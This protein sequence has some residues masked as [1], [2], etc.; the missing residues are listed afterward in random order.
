MTIK[1]ILV[2][3]DFVLD[4]HIY[5]GRRSHFGDNTSAG[6]IL[7][8]QIGGA[9]LVHELLE[10][11]LMVEKE[12]DRKWQSVCAVDDPVK[13]G[14]ACHINPAEQ[15]FAFWRPSPKKVAADK[16]RYWRVSESM[17]FG[18]A[19]NQPQ[20]KK[21]TPAKITKN[22]EIVVISEGGMGFR[23]CKNNWRE[24]A[25]SK[26]KWIVLKTTSPVANGGLWEL[27]TA[28]YSE[29]L[30]VIV[31]AWELRKSPA[32]M[33]AGLSW[34]ETIDGLL[35]EIRQ[36]GTLAGLTRC[37]HLIV[38]FESESALWLDMPGDI[39]NA[40]ACLVYESGTIEGDHN[41]VTEGSAYGFIS[42]LAAAVTW[43]LTQDADNPDF[44]TAL[45]GGLSAMRNLR[46]EGHGLAGKKPDGFPA[47]RLAEVIKQITF[48]YSRA[49]LRPVDPK[50]NLSTSSSPG[51][52]FLRQ[53]Q[54]GDGPVYDLARLVL[55]R[56]PIALENLPHLKIGNLLT[57]D[58]SEVESL[59]TLVQ[60]IRRY[61]KEDSGK[62]PLSIGVFGPPGAGK[63]FA[64][65]ELASLAEKCGWME[66]NLS[67][68]STPNELNGAFHQI[69]D[70]VLQGKLPVAFFDEFD[71][72]SYK[73][74][75]YLLAPMQDG[76]F[77]DGQLTHTLGKCI[78][79]FAGGTSPTYETFG[80]PE[81]KGNEAEN[82]AQRDFRLAKG[83]DFKSRLDAY[84]DVLGPNQR[85]IPVVK[86]SKGN[87]TI[88]KISGR[89][90]MID[91]S[92]IVFPVRRALMIRAQL[93]CGPDEKL[94]MDEGLVHALLHVSNYRHGNRSLEK[95]LQPFASV[96]PDSLH[97]SLLM[98]NA[99]LAMYTDGKA[100]I[101]CCA[102]PPAPFS[103]EAPLTKKQI[104]KIAPAISETYRALGHKKG[105]KLD[106]ETDRDFGQLSEFYQ[107]SNRAAAARMLN[108]LA[109]IGLTLVE[110]CASQDEEEEA[111]QYLEYFLLVLSEA[112]HEGW[113]EWHFTK[114][115]HYAP[116]KKKNKKKKLHNCLLPFLQLSAEDKHKDRE[117][118]RHYPDFARTA[119]MKIVFK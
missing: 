53:T 21:M 86:K 89:D 23:E 56:G 16:K 95:I 93:K 30:I 101:E 73:W 58:R 32:R 115:W 76:K 117:T 6:V 24:D 63:S 40:R 65:K 38:A 42:C 100:F 17:G 64:V 104:E 91:H 45:E 77:Q 44:A 22:P 94:K 68:F 111:K 102:N 50:T 43:S 48:R 31:S 46:E 71:S 35:R 49:L 54:R 15:A 88:E 52:S 18:P 114:G 61:E 55:L 118:I 12:S 81:T 14:D 33:N 105:W 20:C 97:P 107:G 113:M 90:F 119:K 96:R 5:E 37:R 116:V 66:F 75:Q 108:L 85:K 62:K 106:P 51:W 3:G 29:R 9:A 7:K 72:R 2:S 84:L 80:P 26:A 87:G 78:F 103:P 112:E 92:D 34:E 28:K 27:L 10:N 109:I 19:E 57:A 110:G 11:L 59:R 47:K 1:Q 67:Q 25:L 74:L 70:Y 69:R 39:S 99:Q 41:H 13:S 82:D 98:P 83:P 79:V 60:V 8:V 36:G 4:N